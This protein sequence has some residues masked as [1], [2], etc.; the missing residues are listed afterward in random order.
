MNLGLKTLSS[1]STGYAVAFFLDPFWSAVFADCSVLDAKID[2]LLISC[3]ID[4]TLDA[5]AEL[6]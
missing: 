6:T 2:A 4:S 5:Q 3:F 1:P